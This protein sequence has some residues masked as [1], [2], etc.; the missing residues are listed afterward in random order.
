M[1]VKSFFHVYL[2]ISSTKICCN[3]RSH[4]SS[5]RNLARA[6]RSNSNNHWGIR[7]KPKTELFQELKLGHNKDMARACELSMQTVDGRSCTESVSSTPDIRKC[8]RS[9]KL[10]QYDKSHRPAFYGIWPK[11]R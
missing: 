7:K 10:L 4:L 6:V 5:W 1:L 9:K 3:T 2:F 8:K 11:T